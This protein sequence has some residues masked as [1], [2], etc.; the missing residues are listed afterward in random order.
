MK[1]NQPS[2][3]T[4]I[5]EKTKT[6]P[7]GAYS[8][9]QKGHG[10]DACCRIKIFEADEIMKKK[11]LGLKSYISIRRQ[12]VR[13]GKEFDTLTFYISS[14]TQSAWSFAQKI[15][16][17]RKIE[18]NLHWTKDVILNEDNCGL[19][20]AQAA[21]NMAVIRNISFNILIMNGFKS[22]S[23]GISAIGENVKTMWGMITGKK[24]YT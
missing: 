11:W 17:H 21:V 13:D 22:I 8:W 12:G 15:R 2:L 7:I 9:K 4:A 18:N 1:R 3:H 24:A 5:A 6:K 14:E 16:G 10:H 23:E 19:V 20:D